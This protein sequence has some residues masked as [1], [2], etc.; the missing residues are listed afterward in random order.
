MDRDRM[1]DRQV[2]NAEQLTSPE[3]DDPLAVVVTQSI[4]GDNPLIGN[5]SQK[6]NSV[7][8]ILALMVQHTTPPT[9]ISSIQGRPLLVPFLIRTSGI[10]QPNRLG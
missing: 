2:L 8:F 10:S 6:T 9:A 1:A 5:Y 3:A 4:S 7:D